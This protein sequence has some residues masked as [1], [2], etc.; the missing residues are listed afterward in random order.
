MAVRKAAL[1]ILDRFHC[2]CRGAG[3]YSWASMTP[4]QRRTALNLARALATGHAHC[5]QTKARRLGV[6]EQDP[7]FFKAGDFRNGLAW[8]L[9]PR[10]MEA[11]RAGLDVRRAHCGQ[12]WVYV[13]DYR[14]AVW[15]EGGQLVLWDDSEQRVPEFH[16]ALKIIRRSIDDSTE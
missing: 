9:D 3:G 7:D 16:D 12:L 2:R 1:P 8:W 15:A 5:M 14:I 11:G 13:G 6:R 4:W 10:A